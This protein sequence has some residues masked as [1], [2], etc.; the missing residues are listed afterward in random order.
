[1]KERIKSQFQRT[2]YLTAAGQ[3]S[4]CCMKWRSDDSRVELRRL[5]G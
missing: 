3:G 2:Q 4:F 1:M 5:A